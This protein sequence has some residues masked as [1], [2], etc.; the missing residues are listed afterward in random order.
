MKTIKHFIGAFLVY[1]L[2]FNNPKTDEQKLFNKSLFNPWE[3]KR[4]R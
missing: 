4:D 1:T 3:Y 2:K